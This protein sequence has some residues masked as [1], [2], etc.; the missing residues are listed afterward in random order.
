MRPNRGGL[1]L[2]PALGLEIATL[3]KEAKRATPVGL[4]GNVRPLCECP[5]A[6]AE[7][8]VAQTLTTATWT[9]ITLGLS[10]VDNDGI[11]DLANDIIVI[12]YP[13][14]YG[15]WGTVHFAAS[16]GGGSRYSRFL[17]NGG[18]K[19]QTGGWVPVTTS[20]IAVPCE[21]MA[22]LAV[23][24]QIELQGFQNS[25]GNLNTFITDGPS[26]IVVAWMGP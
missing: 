13:G 6:N 26:N 7:Q 10:V 18:A 17:V 4:R 24:Q 20:T 9:R 2:D 21:Y 19:R 1:R 25:G 8:T 23:G 3:D 14:I 5:C 15:M 12:K 22:T 11:V 16:A